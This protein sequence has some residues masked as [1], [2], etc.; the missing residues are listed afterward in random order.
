MYRSKRP[1]ALILSL[2]ILASTL[3]TGLSLASPRTASAASCQTSATL[4]LN[5]TT[6]THGGQLN[7]TGTSWM[8]I[9]LYAQRCG[10]HFFTCLSWDTVANWAPVTWTGEGYHTMSRTRSAS[11]NALYRTWAH[12]S[13]GIP[14]GGSINQNAFSIEIWAP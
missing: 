4:S 3:A 8:S 11:D 5:G 10:F 14:G 1:F 7:C 13:A 9:N 6:F 12:G 2:A